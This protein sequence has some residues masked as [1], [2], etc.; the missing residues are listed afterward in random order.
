MKSGVPVQR[1]PSASVGPVAV[2]SSWVSTSVYVPATSPV[3]E[4]ASQQKPETASAPPMQLLD[5]CMLPMSPCSRAP[6][7][8]NR[9][10]TGTKPPEATPNPAPLTP[11]A[12]EKLRT[13]TVPAAVSENDMR[14]CR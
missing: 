7:L 13:E 6:R 9:L 10:S 2:F 4:P 14:N 12:Q 1:N 8:S 3:V 5:A 11:P